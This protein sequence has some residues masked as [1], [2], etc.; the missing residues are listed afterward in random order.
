[1]DPP[2]VVIIGQPS[3]AMADR[4]ETAE[5]ARI[6]AQVESLGPNGLKK[7]EEELTKAKTEHDT[8][9]PTDILTSFPVPSVDSI[10]WIDVKSLQQPGTGRQAVTPTE[11]QLSKHISSDGQA[12]PFFVQ[13]DHVTSDFVTVN[14]LF[15]LINL[16]DRLRPYVTFIFPIILFSKLYAGTSQR[17][18]LHSSPCPFKLNQDKNSH[19]KRWLID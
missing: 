18:C 1:M 8:P 9:I 14:G 4:L 6:A 10:S 3:A 11:T 13:Y 16:P 19:M 15:S 2:C 12:L 5:K 17:I 7:A